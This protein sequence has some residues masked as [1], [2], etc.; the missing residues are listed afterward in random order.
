MTS[1]FVAAQD[2]ANILVAAGRALSAPPPAPCHRVLKVLRWSREAAADA[3][4][5]AYS[6]ASILFFIHASFSFQQSPVIKLPAAY[7]CYDIHRQVILH[8]AIVDMKSRRRVLYWKRISF[9]GHYIEFIAIAPALYRYHAFSRVSVRWLELSGISL[10]FIWRHGRRR[11]EGASQSI[12][13]RRPRRVVLREMSRRALTFPPQR[14][15]RTPLE[16]P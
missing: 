5:A 14:F 9:R 15:C 7:T 3:L 13:S 6:H 1:H 16:R 2:A 12:K 4:F 10:T 8:Y 11:D